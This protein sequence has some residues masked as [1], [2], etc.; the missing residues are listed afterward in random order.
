M[1]FECTWEFERG[2]SSSRESF[3][4]DEIPE[5]EELEDLASNSGEEEAREA[6]SSESRGAWTLAGLLSEFKKT[7]VV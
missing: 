5:G 3:R 1:R 6:S 4:E 2:S 7:I